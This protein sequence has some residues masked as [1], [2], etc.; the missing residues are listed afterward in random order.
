MD[1]RA[2]GDRGAG[3]PPRIRERLDV[4]PAR[5]V[6]PGVVAP[7]SDERRDL[8]AFEEA[9]LALPRCPLAGPL[10]VEAAPPGAV[11]ALHV[12]RTQRLAFDS[13]ALDEL[14]D[15]IATPIAEFEENAHPTPD[16][17]RR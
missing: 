16:P 11:S 3:E 10:L 13:I 5:V 15:E 1:G 8:L 6:G 12:A 9:R 4:P 2:L 17:A 7:R 14:E